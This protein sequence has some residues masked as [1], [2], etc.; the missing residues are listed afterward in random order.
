MNPLLALIGLLVGL[1]VG[2]SGIGG[3]SLMTPLLILVLRINPLV[4]VGTDLAYS[5]PTKLL[6]A[7]THW[8][9]G[10][11]NR[12]VVKNLCLGGLPGVVVGLI[13]LF[14]LRSVVDL[15]VLSGM[16]KHAVGVMV[17]I[18][19]LALVLTPLLSRLPKRQSNRPLLLGRFSVERRTIAL[20]AVVGFA[21]A[22]TSIGSGSITV[23]LLYMLMP[24]LGLR[25]VVGS[26]VV[27]AAVLVPTAALGQ[28][29]LGTVNLAISANLLIG[30]L[31][32]VWIGSRLCA[33]MP[34]TFLRPAL[35][36]VLVWA[37]S[38]LVA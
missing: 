15:K 6:G 7:I 14:R 11:V 33:I 29:S 8:R 22:L 34:T 13:V 23:P 2:L 4:A 27:F 1:L 21:V 5:A 17:F 25:N 38:N 20:G 28:L 24:A 16:T 10:T 31:P 30:S 18:A 32:G 35:A 19:A 37:G 12:E 9:Q 3:S 26:D 36:G